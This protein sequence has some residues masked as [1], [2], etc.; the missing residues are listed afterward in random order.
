YHRCETYAASFALRSS[1]Q[2][3]SRGTAAKQSAS[4][5]DR[6]RGQPAAH[7]ATGALGWG[8]APILLGNR[9]VPRCISGWG[10]QPIDGSQ[11]QVLNWS[12][13]PRDRAG[14]ALARRVFRRLRWGALDLL[15]RG[16]SPAVVTRR[17]VRKSAL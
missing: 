6:H 1:Y 13:S 4:A 12:C 10:L 9:V 15:I 8:G 7:G 3:H 14:Q 5:R 2:F 17:G 16:L 11:R